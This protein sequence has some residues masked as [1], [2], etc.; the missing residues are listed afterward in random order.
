MNRNERNLIRAISYNYDNTE[1]LVELLEQAQ[2]DTE[3]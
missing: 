3:D 2:A 1:G